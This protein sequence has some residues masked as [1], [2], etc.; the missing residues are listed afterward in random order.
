MSHY[1]GRYGWNTVD[2]TGGVPDDEVREL[3]D[4]SYDAAVAALPR[5]RRPQAPPG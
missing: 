3:I 5:S 1:V 4:A 2:W